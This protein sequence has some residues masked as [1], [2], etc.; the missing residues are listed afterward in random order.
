[1]KLGPVP[2]GV[3]IPSLHRTLVDKLV[4]LLLPLVSPAEQAVAPATCDSQDSVSQLHWS[5]SGGVF[6]S[7]ILLNITAKIV[8]K[9]IEATR[10]SSMIHSILFLRHRHLYL[11][12]SQGNTHKCHYHYL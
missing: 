11:L 2:A 4:T 9:P 5:V 10:N 8:V 3:K 6:G 12:P 1:M 7:I